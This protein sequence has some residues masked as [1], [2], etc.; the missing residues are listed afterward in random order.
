MAMAFI[1]NALNVGDWL[2]KNTENAI[3]NLSR[4]VS[5]I[6]IFATEI[7][8]LRLLGVGRK[9]TKALSMLEVKYGAIR[10]KSLWLFTKGSD[11]QK[12]RVMGFSKSL[13]KNLSA[14]MICLVFIVDLI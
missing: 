13:K 8:A 10:I 3:R 6:T 1:P 9:K 5:E 7:S 2:A 14:F 11:E 4:K 12:S